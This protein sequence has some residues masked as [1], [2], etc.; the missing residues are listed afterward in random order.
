MLSGRA[1]A[2]GVF[3][4]VALVAA[5]LVGCGGGEPAGGPTL[6]AKPSA[7]SSSSDAG[8]SDGGGASDGG[9]ESSSRTANLPPENAVLKAPDFKDY[10]G[11]KYETDQGAQETAKYFVDAMYYGYATGDTEPLKKVVD[12]GQCEN[13]QRVIDGIGRWREK[14]KHISPADISEDDIWVVESNDNFTQVEYWY[15][16]N[17]VVVTEAGQSTETVKGERKASAFRL[18]Y[19]NGS[20]QVQEGV[21]KGA[22]D[23]SQ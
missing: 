17:D 11:I 1:R 10:T 19:L 2:C 21:W 13:C 15:T 12:S 16:V 14:S 18:R 5:G 20:W 4:V 9:G 22:D 3:G 8:G 23:V 7:S 6:A